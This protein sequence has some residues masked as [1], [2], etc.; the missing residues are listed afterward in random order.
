MVVE[1][2]TYSADYDSTSV[3]LRAVYGDSEE[4]KTF[5]K[6]TP[7]AHLQINITNPDASSYF[8]VGQEYYLDFNKV[9]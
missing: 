5:S 7:S 1:S 2:S 3:V 6:W 9:E 8:E 4:N